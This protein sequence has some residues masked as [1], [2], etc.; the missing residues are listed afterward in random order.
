MNI[1]HDT[2]FSGTAATTDKT[3]LFDGASW[4]YGPDLP[5]GRFGH[6][7]VSYT[8]TEIFLF[9]GHSDQGLGTL[10]TTYSYDFSAPNVGWRQ[11]K[12]MPQAAHG[13][14]VGHLR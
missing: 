3:E 9:S 1:L 6:A 14:I 8:A 10:D 12:V 2:I 5:E 11:K 13:V 4:T 7:V